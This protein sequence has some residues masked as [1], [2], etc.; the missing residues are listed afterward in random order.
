MSWIW[1]ALVTIR[2]TSAIAFCKYSTS[3]LILSLKYMFTEDVICVDAAEVLKC[4]KK[5]WGG[6]RVYGTLSLEIQSEKRG[7]L[8]IF[9]SKVEDPMPRV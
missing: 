7:T 6:G 1:Q 8:S 9:G 2:T 3:H 4:F 5:W